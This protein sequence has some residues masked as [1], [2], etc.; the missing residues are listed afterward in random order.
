MNFVP[1]S[2]PTNGG[3]SSR[4]Q[5]GRGSFRG[6]PVFL[7]Q[8]TSEDIALVRE[9]LDVIE[10]EGTVSLEDAIQALRNR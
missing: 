9:S 2:N 8:T 1:M 6:R 7:V 10:R 5:T 3:R 4:R